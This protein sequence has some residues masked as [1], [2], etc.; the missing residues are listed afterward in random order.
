ASVMSDALL[1]HPMRWC[2]SDCANLHTPLC[3][4]ESYMLYVFLHSINSRVLDMFLDYTYADR[5]HMNAYF[6][7]SIC[8]E[9]D[10]V[11]IGQGLFSKT[12]MAEGISREMKILQSFQHEGQL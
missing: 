4:G 10:S 6:L 1:M 7:G 8:E 12:A 5:Q 9:K 11:V 2:L 3:L